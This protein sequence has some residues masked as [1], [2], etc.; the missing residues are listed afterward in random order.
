MW[1]TCG[2]W[3][4]N[5]LSRLQPHH[6]RVLNFSCSFTSIMLHSI[7][8]SLV[9]EYRMT[10]TG[11]KGCFLVNVCCSVNLFCQFKL[12]ISRS[13]FF[14]LF[15]LLFTLNVTCGSKL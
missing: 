11:L 8:T 7:K 3:E 6:F 13:K 15:L 4:P 2:Y 12:I 1:A 10:V 9:H 5:L 14:V